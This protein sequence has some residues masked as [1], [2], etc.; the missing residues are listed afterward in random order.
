MRVLKNVLAF[1]VVVLAGI[2]CGSA[3]EIADSVE[4]EIRK[5]AAS[6]RSR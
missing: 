5:R 2:A 3:L 4:T 6:H 1:V